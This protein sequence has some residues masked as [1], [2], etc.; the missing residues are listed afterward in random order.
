[1]RNEFI[2]DLLEK[3]RQDAII[4]KEAKFGETLQFDPTKY[5]LYNLLE[6]LEDRIDSLERRPASSCNCNND[7]L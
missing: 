5:A 2:K 1:M 6:R 4:N 7:L 3:I